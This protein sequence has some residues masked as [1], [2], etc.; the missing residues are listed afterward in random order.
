M[1]KN[2]VVVL[3]SKSGFWILFPVYSDFLHTF[4]NALTLTI[5]L[6]FRDLDKRFFDY[7]RQLLIN[8]I[9]LFNHQQQRLEMVYGIQ[10]FVNVF[11]V[12]PLKECM[13]SFKGSVWN[14][15]ICLA[16]IPKTPI[17]EMIMGNMGTRCLSACP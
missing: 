10:P 12:V 8:T 15:A 7:R 14:C 2:E 5:V 3:H 11:P 17:F 9:L 4:F 13:N 1:V 16:I 6:V